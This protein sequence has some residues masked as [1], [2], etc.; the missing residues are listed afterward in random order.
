M[1]FPYYFHLGSV[2]VHP[3]LIFEAIAY[4]VGFRLY[5]ALRRKQGDLLGDVNR[6]S[7]IAAAAVGAAIGS[8]VLYW[9]EDLRLTL[10]HWNNPAFVLGG[11]TIVGALIGGLFAVEYVKGRLGIV[12]RTGDLFAVP[13]CLG[14]AIGRI[15]C[16]LSGTEDHTAGVATTLPWGINFGDGVTRHPTQLYE[17]VFALALGIF[18][19]RLLEKPHREGDIFKAFMVCYFAFRLACDFLKP[20]VRLILGLSSIQC[21]CVAMLCYYAKDLT[22]WFGGKEGASMLDFAREGTSDVKITAPS[23]EAAQ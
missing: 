5:L 13:L 23:R 18:L 10:I 7:V 1:A 2:R 12:R 9:F 14:I 15:G 19:W 21:A 16:F 17:L 6:W 8:K 11:K 22:R 20:D 3:H 4:A